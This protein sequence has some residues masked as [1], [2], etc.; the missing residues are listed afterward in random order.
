MD[1]SKVRLEDGLVFEYGNKE[2]YLTTIR[3]ENKYGNFVDKNII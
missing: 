3:L 1:K 2:V